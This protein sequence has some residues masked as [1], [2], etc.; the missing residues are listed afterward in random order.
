MIAAAQSSKRGSGHVVSVAKFEQF[1]GIA[2][3][4]DVDKQ[5]LKRYSD[6]INQKIYDLLI[7]AQA[8]AKANGRVID[9]DLKHPHAE[10]WQRCFRIFDLLM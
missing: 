4:L 7:R 2:A 10:H 9:G 5:D 3:G 6:L 8:T 1:F